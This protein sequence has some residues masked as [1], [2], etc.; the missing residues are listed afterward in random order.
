MQT[1]GDE[2]NIKTLFRELRLHDESVAPRF[3]TVWNQAQS[4]TRASR[5]LNP[6]FVVAAALLIVSLFS[7]ALWLRAR[8]RSQ[9]Q[10]AAAISTTS[11]TVVQPPQALKPAPSRETPQRASYRANV[12]RRAMRL[13]EHRRL[14]LLALREAELRNAAAVSSWQSPTAMLMQSP[15]DDL[16]SSLPQLYRSVNEVNS[17]LSDTKK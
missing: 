6:S 12:I 17:F 5:V 13:A 2:E 3:S 9:Q 1:I 11:P 15:A 16:L 7:I 4:G 10:N 14:E 8:L